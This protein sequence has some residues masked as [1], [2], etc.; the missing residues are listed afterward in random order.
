MHRLKPF[1]QSLSL[2]FLCACAAAAAAQSPAKPRYFFNDHV[3]LVS[4]DV[5]YELNERLAQAERQTSN[6]ILVVIY[7]RLPDGEVLE[8]YTLKAFQA[9]GWAGPART[10][11]LCSLPS[12]TLETATAWTA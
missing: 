2:L 1:G 7:P 12:W 9:W 10:T 8:E 3:G 11:A 6:Q 4:H 5:V